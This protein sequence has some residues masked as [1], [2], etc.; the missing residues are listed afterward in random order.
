V[1]I[2]PVLLLAV[3]AVAWVSGQ[4]AAAA[5]VTAVAAGLYGWSLWRHPWWP[6]RSCSGSKSHRD[7]IWVKA[8]GRCRRCGGKG[9]FPRLGV[10][11]LTPGRAEQ[12]TSGRSGRYG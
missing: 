9:Q 6:C 7:S 11:I 12:L 4:V 3:V 8:Y 10:K 5:L 2:H 1:K